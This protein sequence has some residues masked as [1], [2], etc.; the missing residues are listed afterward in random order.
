M[1]IS[2]TI[3]NQRY[4]RGGHTDI[5]NMVR[6]SAV[7]GKRRKFP[8]GGMVISLNVEAKESRNVDDGDNVERVLISLQLC[9]H[10]YCNH[11]GKVV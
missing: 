6:S 10:F 7:T 4:A 9:K 1:L 2:A 3:H 11:Q 5:S 8:T